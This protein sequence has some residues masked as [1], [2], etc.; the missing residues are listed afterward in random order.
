VELVS[1]DLLDTTGSAAALSQMSDVTHVVY[2][3]LYEEPGLIAGWRSAEQMAT[4]LTMLQNVLDPLLE[5]APIQHISIL[6]GTKAYGAHVE[7]ML[8]PGRERSPRHQHENFYWLQEDELRGRATAAG[9][10]WSVFRPVV[11]FG[12]AIGGNMN[13]IPA[14]GTYAALMR[15]RGEPLHWPGGVASLT[16]AVD[17]DLVGAALHWAATHEVARDQIFNVANGDVFTM[18]NVWP[19]IADAFGM[20]VGTNRP[21]QLATEVPA[22]QS[23]WAELHDRFQLSSPLD[24]DTFVGQSFIYT[25]MLCGYG[26]DRVRP[27]SLVSTIKLRQSGFDMCMDTEDMFAKWIAHHQRTRLLPPRDWVP[28]SP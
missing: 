4:N 19:A 23:E 26:N 18:A 28:E 15:Q 3:A 16:E 12:E 13:P 2:A 5:V 14:L 25:D 1:V 17:A 8:V 22:G 11:I 7:P 6:Q 24:L 10:G 27:P 9:F 20:E 21:M